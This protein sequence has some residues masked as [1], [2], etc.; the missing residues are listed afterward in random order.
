[1]ANIDFKGFGACVVKGFPL[2]KGNLVLNSA[3]SEIKEPWL[4]SFQPESNANEGVK[5]GTIRTQAFLLALPG[6]MLIT[7]EPELCGQ[8][9]GIAELQFRQDELKQDFS[10][11]IEGLVKQV[12]SSFQTIS[13]ACSPSLKR[14][15]S[16]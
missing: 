7:T 16:N 11:A 4:S 8:M 1:M 13:Q 6:Y 10:H 3:L 15:V 9:A 5:G 2:E 14:Q 12:T